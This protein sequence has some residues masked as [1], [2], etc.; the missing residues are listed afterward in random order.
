[1]SGYVTIPGVAFVL[2]Y[3]DDM[4]D[5]IEYF[6]QAMLEGRIEV[7]NYRVVDGDSRATQIVNFTV[8]TDIRVTNA[9]PELGD[10]V[11]VITTSL[12]NITPGDTPPPRP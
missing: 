7:I 5:V 6:T 10:D 8:V 4:D 3:I 12:G 11:S 9:R 2:E 1:V